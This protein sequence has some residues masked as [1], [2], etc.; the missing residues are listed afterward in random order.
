MT[1]Q[2]T[3][4][5]NQATIDALAARLVELANSPDEA[6]ARA[7]LSALTRQIDALK[8]LQVGQFSVRAVAAYILALLDKLNDAFPLALADARSGGPNQLTA[9]VINRAR[10]IFLQSAY[11]AVHAKRPDMA[12]AEIARIT[13]ALQGTVDMDAERALLNLL[14]HIET[15]NVTRSGPQPR[16]GRPTL[17]KL[18]IWGDRFIDSAG[19][20]VLSSLLAPGN[21]A[22]LKDLGPVILHVHTRR[23][24]APRLRALDATKELQRQVETEFHVIPEEVFPP[25]PILGGAALRCNL[26]AMAQFD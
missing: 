25:H 10:A 3:D 20:N 22:A 13:A 4:T 24:D 6:A 19:H 16:E 9:F 12:R 14:S 21:A 8:D 26:L 7:E 11:T 15:I 17:L 5:A 23:G 18:A 2:P 1:S